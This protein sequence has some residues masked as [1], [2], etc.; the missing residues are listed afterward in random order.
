MML[1][2]FANFTCQNLKMKLYVTLKFIIPRLK[3]NLRE[4]SKDYVMIV[5]E[6]IP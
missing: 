3:I 5:D 6:S 2:T 1:L 4:K